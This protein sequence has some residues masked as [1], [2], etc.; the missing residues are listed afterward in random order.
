M[1]SANKQTIEI[2]ES[3]RFERSSEYG[4]QNILNTKDSWN[5]RRV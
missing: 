1:L 3:N 4:I 5:T 2:I